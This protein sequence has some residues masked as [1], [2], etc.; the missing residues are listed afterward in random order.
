MEYLIAENQ[1]YLALAQQN[2]I[3]YLLIEDAYAV[4]I[5]L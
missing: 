3:D 2:H 1:H 5:A 4:N